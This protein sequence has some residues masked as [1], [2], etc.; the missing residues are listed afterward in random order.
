MSAYVGS[1]LIVDTPYVLLEHLEKK[2]LARLCWKKNPSSLEYRVAIMAFLN[3]LTKQHIELML[4][5]NTFA[6]L[7]SEEDQEWSRFYIKTL[8]PKT[9]LQKLACV[10]AGNLFQKM[11][12]EEMHISAKYDTYALALF[13][14]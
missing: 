2:K 12:I 4:F 11:I 8:L 7:I 3:L 10:V 6:G 9:Q 13:S 14:E 1:K 5:N